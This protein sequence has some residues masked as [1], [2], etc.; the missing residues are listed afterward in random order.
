M[1]KKPAIVIPLDGSETAL[2]AF[3]AAE[4]MTNMM[5]GV[6]HIVHVAE[7]M[8]PQEELLHRL[9]VPAKPSV[10]EFVLHQLKGEP[11]EAILAFAASVGAAMLVMSSHGWTFN[12]EY[13]AGHVTLEM[14]RRAAI[15]VLLVRPGSRSVPG[16]DWKPM[17]ML[18]PLDGTPEASAGLN[19][20][21]DL[22]VDIARSTKAGIDVLHVAQPGQR[23]PATA[24]SLTV[25]TYLDYPQY[26]WPGWAEEF[27]ERFMHAPPDVKL[28]LFHRDGEPAKVM[29]EFAT[30][31][32]EYMI[33]LTWRGHLEKK[34]AELVKEVLRSTDVPVLLLRSEPGS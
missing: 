7:G 17:R 12:P 25:P 2:A 26:E 13:L 33:V 20:M 18:V 14:I 24:G 30:E 6:L 5:G 28:R 3:G 16:P 32:Q 34:R 27:R 8:V 15:P 11:V 23:Q 29:L 9:H 21:F 22:L 31:K 10:K 19:L 4:A 1:R